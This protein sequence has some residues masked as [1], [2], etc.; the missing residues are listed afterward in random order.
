MDGKI[1]SSTETSGR[2]YRNE[3]LTTLA[4]QGASSGHVAV[5]VLA[6]FINSDN[7]SEHYSQPPALWL[8][9]PLCLYLIIKLWL[10]VQRREVEDDPIIWAISNR[11]SIGIV[12]LCGLV[13]IYA[14]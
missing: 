4:S 10:N 9:C 3:D 14:V 13:V 12:M 8:L 7:V 6:L 1:D 11:V 2:G 5:L